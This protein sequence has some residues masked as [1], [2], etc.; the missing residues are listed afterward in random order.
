MRH[1]GGH[2]LKWQAYCK[3]LRAPPLNSVEC[4]I[5]KATDFDAISTYYTRSS[6]TAQGAC[7][8]FVANRQYERPCCM[9]ARTRKV[10]SRVGGSGVA[11]VV[12]AAMRHEHAAC[13]LVEVRKTASGP[14]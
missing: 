6:Q 3:Y 2:G 11:E 12:Y 5:F 9:G 1:G 14:D 4:V 10:R 8:T 7:S 13:A